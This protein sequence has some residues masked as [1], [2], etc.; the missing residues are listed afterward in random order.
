VRVVAIEAGLAA[1]CVA[2]LPAPETGES[3]GTDA[4]T[5][6]H[7]DD[8]RDGYGAAA[9]VETCVP[10]PGWTRDDRDCYD[11]NADAHPK[12]DAF[13]AVHRGDATFDYDCDEVTAFLLPE[14]G[15][16]DP[17]PSCAYTPGWQEFRAGC[18]ANRQYVIACDRRDREMDCLARFETRRQ[19]CR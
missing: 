3:S 1:M 9:A 6:W 19:M 5:A 12:Q 15:G 17:F 11:D 2:C 7:P 16:C 4:C 13:F 14:I 10:E 18:G 8:D